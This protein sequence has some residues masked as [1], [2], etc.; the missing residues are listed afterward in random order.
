MRASLLQRGVELE[1]RDFF[2]RPLSEG[3]LQELLGDRPPSEL[4]AWRSPSFK[5]L[6][7]EAETVTDQ[8]L[9]RLMAQE[10]RLIR[11]PL[12]RVGGRLIIGAN[13]KELD[14]AFR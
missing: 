6:G 14:E 3:E 10:P 2:Q 4:F 1:E 13:W 5:A 12:T 9:V 11:R 8:E 7:L